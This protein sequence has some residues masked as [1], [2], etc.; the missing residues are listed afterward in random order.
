METI[1]FYESKAKF[2]AAHCI[3]SKTSWAGNT[4]SERLI[5]ARKWNAL[6]RM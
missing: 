4:S 5:K 6:S 2:P 3:W 1:L